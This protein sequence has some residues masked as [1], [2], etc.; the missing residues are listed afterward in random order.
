[1]IHSK[2]NKYNFEYNQVNNIDSKYCVQ[3]GTIFIAFSP[4]TLFVMRLKNFKKKYGYLLVICEEFTYHR[5]DMVSLYPK[6][7]LD[8]EQGSTKHVKRCNQV[9]EFM[10]NLSMYLFY[11]PWYTDLPFISEATIIKR[12]DYPSFIFHMIK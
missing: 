10:H 12:D 4:L 3:E 7:N 11:N 2:D 6:R 8:T 9:W 1:M 5:W